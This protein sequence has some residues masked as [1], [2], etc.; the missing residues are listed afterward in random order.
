MRFRKPIIAVTAAGLMALAACGGSESGGGGNE[1]SPEQDL[2][3][4][5]DTGRTT[6]PDREGPVQIEGA[7]E[8]GTVKVIS[9]NGLNTMDPS[10]AYYQNTTSILTSLVTR[11]LTQYV[12]DEESGNMILV[13]DLAEDLGTPNEDFTEWKFQL[14]DGIKYEDGTDVKPEDYVFAIKRS[15]DRAAFPSGPAF[16]NDYFVDGDTYGG[17]Y[18][19]PNGEFT[20]ADVDENNVLTIRT[21]VPFPDLPYWVSFAAFTP[22]PE[23]KADPRTYSRHPLATG[24]Y[25][26]SKYTPEK[27]LELVKNPNWDPATDPARTAYPDSYVFDFQ[28][29]SAQID[30]L[31]LADEGDAQTTLSYDDVLN[32]NYREFS[33]NHEDR[34]VVGGYPLTNYWAPDYRKVTDIRVRQALAWAYPYEDAILAGGFI[35]NVTRTFGTNTLVPG[36]AGREEFNPLEGHEPGQTD[37]KQSCALLEEAGATGYE[38][39]WPYAKDDDQAVAAK[40]KIVAA[41]REGCFTP[42]PLATTV[43]DLSTVRSDPNANINVR[44]AGWIADWPSGASVIPP[45]Y[46]STNVKDTLGANYAV[47][48][49]PDIDAEIEEARTLPLEDQPAAWNAIDEKILTE[50]FPLFVTSYGGV[51]MMHGSKIN[52]HYVDNTIGMP[53]WKNIWVSQ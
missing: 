31:M 10:D 23:A 43:A 42:K 20:A 39:R 45:I 9:A 6:D 52:G 12:Y 27:S 46:E 29:E 50:Y 26:F 24:P 36:T 48:N 22:M 37:P 5:G 1:G 19:D 30:E 49:E 25:M 35:Q 21:R 15:Y 32:A 18:T 38:I 44:P 40:D 51:A 3:N 11:A 7:T 41:L 2:S 13:P 34:L 8:G 17:P 53:T 4:V 14:R 16:S 33:T 47:F 28:V